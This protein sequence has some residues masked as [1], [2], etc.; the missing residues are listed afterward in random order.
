MNK[1]PIGIISHYKRVRLNRLIDI[2]IFA[3]IVGTVHEQKRD[4][5]LEDLDKSL[6]QEKNWIT[7]TL[8]GGGNFSKKTILVAMRLRNNR[9]R[10]PA[11]NT[12]GSAYPWT[13]TVT[14]ELSLFSSKTQPP[15]LVNR[16]FS[17]CLQ[18]NKYGN[19]FCNINNVKIAICKISAITKHVRSCICVESSERAS[20]FFEAIWHFLG[21]KWKRHEEEEEDFEWTKRRRF[22]TWWHWIGHLNGALEQIWFFAARHKGCGSRSD[23]EYFTMSVSGLKLELESPTTTKLLSLLKDTYRLVRLL[24]SSNDRS[25][26]PAHFQLHFSM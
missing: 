2:V 6:S 25:K 1:I 8:W 19:T 10:T 11:S 20:T 14:K 16:S 12:Q 23:G 24:H 21:K 5:S 22:Y 13:R 15:N 7:R 17:I 3:E 4:Y 9:L 18:S 26:L